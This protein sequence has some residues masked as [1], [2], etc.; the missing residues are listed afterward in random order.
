MKQFMTTYKLITGSYCGGEW[1][2]RVSNYSIT[3]P[4]K[5]ELR[6]LKSK[7]IKDKTSSGSE[8]DF[9]YRSG[10][11]EVKFSDDIWKKVNNT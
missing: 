9:G 6:L 11:V 8:I 7:I 2:E 5:K 10:I 1:N 4:T 3:A